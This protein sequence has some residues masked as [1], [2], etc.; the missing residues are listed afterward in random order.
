MSC[1]DSTQVWGHAKAEKTSLWGARLVTSMC[2]V[3]QPKKI[4]CSDSSLKETL[5]SDAFEKLVTGN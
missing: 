1:T 3:R 2:C 5:L 4:I